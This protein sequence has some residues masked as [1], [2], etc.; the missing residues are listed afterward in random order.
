MIEWVTL[1]VTMGTAGQTIGI[2]STVGK[3]DMTVDHLIASSNGV[4][5]I[6]RQDGRRLI[7]LTECVVLLPNVYKVTG[8]GGGEGGENLQRGLAEVTPRVPRVQQVIE[9]GIIARG[10][11][12]QKDYPLSD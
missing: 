11:T 3:L 5:V 10:N 6:D 8:G 7:Y 12:L 2:E 1:D 9:S 4:R